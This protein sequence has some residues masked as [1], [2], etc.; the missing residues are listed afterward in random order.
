MCLG[1]WSLSGLIN[2]EDLKKVSKM[3]EV[4]LAKGDA[5]ADMLMPEGYEY[6]MYE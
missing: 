6:N 2:D 4:Q 1:S 5:S 3:Q